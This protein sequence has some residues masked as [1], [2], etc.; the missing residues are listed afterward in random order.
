MTKKI[1][2]ID[3]D[4]DDIDFFIEAI[5]TLDSSIECYKATNGEEGL[6]RLQSDLPHPDYI[7]LDLNMPRLN[8]KEFLTLVKKDPAFSD[9][10][11]IMYSTSG[12]ESD[13]RESIALGA[14]GFI[15]KPTRLSDLRDK[16]QGALQGAALKQS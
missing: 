2:I 10:P 13:I 12:I 9:I 11:V 4:I 7:F 5:E 15:V 6:Q 14:C 3:D 16:I 1:L 8:G